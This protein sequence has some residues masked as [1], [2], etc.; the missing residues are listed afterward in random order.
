MMREV[1]TAFGE[2]TSLLKLRVHVPF[3]DLISRIM[4]FL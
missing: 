4:Q 3:F 2:I 1:R